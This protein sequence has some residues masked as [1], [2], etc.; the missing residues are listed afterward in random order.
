MEN[1]SLPLSQITR[2]WRY[3]YRCLSLNQHILKTGGGEGEEERVNSLSI[4][5]CLMWRLLY[6]MHT[7]FVFFNPYHFSCILSCQQNA[8]AKISLQKLKDS[9][10][11]FSWNLTHILWRFI[12]IYFN[13][14]KM[15]STYAEY[16]FSMCILWY[17]MY[18]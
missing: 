8:A 5:L 10:D 9:D 16:L 2:N 7:E 11:H 13:M 3:I 18:K 14:F 17:R 12:P 1:L 15:S 4:C 6:K